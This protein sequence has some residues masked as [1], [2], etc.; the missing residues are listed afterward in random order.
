MKSEKGAI[1]NGRK[2]EMEE[3]AEEEENIYRANT[4]KGGKRFLF[5]F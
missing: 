5:H 4:N 3:D 1:H 2:K